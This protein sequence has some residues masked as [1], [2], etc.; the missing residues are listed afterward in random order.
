M[1]VRQLVAEAAARLS[2]AGVASAQ[3]DAQLLLAH[4]WSKASDRSVDLGELQRRDIL[5]VDVP[6]AAIER[7]TVLVDERAR[8]VPLQHLTGKAPFRH[9]ELSVGPGV[10]VPRPETE[11]LVDAVLSHAPADGV[12]VDLCAGS[13]AIALAVKSERPDLTVYAVE[14]SPEAAAWTSRNIADTGLNVKLSVEDARTALPELVGG[15]DV[16]VSNPPYVPV[17]MVPRDAEVAEHDPELAL[18][19]GSADGLLFPVQIAE[20]A[21]RL[22]RPGGMLFMEHAETQG[23]SLPKALLDRRGFDHTHDESDATGRPRMTVAR[24]EGGAQRDVAASPSDRPHR[25]RSSVR[26]LV[27]D[28][29]D[30]CLLYE[31]S[32]N[33]L[34]PAYTWWSTPGGGIDPGE[35]AKSAAV[36][37]MWE[38]TGLRITEADL[39][40]PL[41]TRTVVHGFSDK[42]DTQHDTFYAV[43]VG[44]FEPAPAHLTPEEAAT[45]LQWRWWTATDVAASA[46][47]FWPAETSELITAAI[48]GTPLDLPDVEESS[49]PVTGDLS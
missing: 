19:G 15:V 31:D 23:E 38:E 46:Q 25:T 27:I 5:G 21:S 26:V 44:H 12:V 18:Y 13:G 28:E 9:L 32:D 35:D 47:R 36:R 42:I 40:G 14:L 11:M 24:K 43:H 4:A 1:R 8:R 41:A 34:T 20:R 33:G 39:I 17:G 22:L 48:A 10:F 2:D 49:V 16:V 6:D 45:M 37:E 30:R 29:S 3:V 7:F